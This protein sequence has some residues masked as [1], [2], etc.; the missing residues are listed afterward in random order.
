MDASVFLALLDDADFGFLTHSELT[1]AAFGCEVVRHPKG[2][3]MNKS[4]RE[5]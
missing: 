5:E 1:R 4:L 3:N 2:I